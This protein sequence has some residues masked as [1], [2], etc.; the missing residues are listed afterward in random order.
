MERPYGILPTGR[1]TT[2]VVR[3]AIM[4]TYRVSF[5]NKHP[6]GQL[7]VNAMCFGVTFVGGIAPTNLDELAEAF[8]TALQLKYESLIPPETLSVGATCSEL[9][10]GGLSGGKS[11]VHDDPG[12]R[13]GDTLPSQVAGLIRLHVAG[14]TGRHSGR[15]YMPASTEADN[16]DN[17]A[18]STTYKANLATFATDL[19]AGIAITGPGLVPLWSG[20]AYL[21]VY[22][23]SIAGAVTPTSVNVASAWATHRSRSG[24]NRGDLPF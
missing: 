7:M 23:R 11:A 9:P 17:G 21:K 6:D 8:Y 1:N 24:I 19:L 15:I 3:E 10:S 20:T 2:N 22:A 13:T 5:F 14:L 16:P 18:P 4:P 12:T